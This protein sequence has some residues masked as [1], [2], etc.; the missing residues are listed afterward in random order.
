MIHHCRTFWCH[1]HYCAIIGYMTD[2]TTSPITIKPIEPS[3]EEMQFLLHAVN[4][5]AAAYGTAGL[6]EVVDYVFAILSG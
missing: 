3:M 2:I 1:A 5:Y 4:E 6:Q